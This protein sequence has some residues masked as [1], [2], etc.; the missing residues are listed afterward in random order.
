MIEEYAHLLESSAP[1]Q[2]AY[3]PQIFRLHHTSMEDRKS[4]ETLL[5]SGNVRAIND[6]LPAQLRELLKLRN[7]SSRLSTSD[8][9]AMMKAHL[10]GIE[11]EQYGVWVYYPWSGRL[12]HLLDE[13]EY[14]EVRTARNKNKISS[15]EQA[16]LSGKKIGVIGL[17]VGQSVAL[18]LAMERAFGELR[19][20]DFDDLELSNMNRIRSGAHEMASLKVVN[21][22]REIAEI[23]PFLQVTIFPDG[24]TDDNMDAFFEDGGRLDLLMEECDSLEM[25]L[26]SRIKARSLRIP[27][28]M[29]TSDRG[30]VDVERFDEEPNREIL[31]G[32]V[33]GLA[34]ERLADMSMEEKLPYLMQL[35]GYEHLSPRMKASLPELGKTLS[36]WPQLATSVMMGGAIV[37]DIA[38]KIFTGVP[39]ASGRYY[40][41]PDE[42]LKRGPF[43]A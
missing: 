32:L 29:D 1:S 11:M 20:A 27:V 3:R 30:M 31:H 9:E 42:T 41:D 22:A 21:V 43:L 4:L 25:K 5:Q 15:D 19:L 6:A 24:L 38:R 7:P 8:F 36:A 14:A 12:V 40:F 35:A 34:I 37:A 18:A 17:S 16:I 10:D 33:R 28:L 23:D 13:A 39:V 2:V 26:K